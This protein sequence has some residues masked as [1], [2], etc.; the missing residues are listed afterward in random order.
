MIASRLKDKEPRLAKRSMKSLNTAVAQAAQRLCK[1]GKLDQATRK[2]KYGRSL[3]RV[4]G[5]FTGSG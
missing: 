2:G 1:E 3:Y 5:K 4:A